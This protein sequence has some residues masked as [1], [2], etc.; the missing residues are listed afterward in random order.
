MEELLSAI[1]QT[2]N[3]FTRC[4]GV[5]MGGGD[6]DGDTTCGGGLGDD[7]LTKTD[8]TTMAM[9]NRRSSSPCSSWI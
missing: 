9:R 2:H 6:G 7:T 5:D 4:H 3:E 8:I 1:R